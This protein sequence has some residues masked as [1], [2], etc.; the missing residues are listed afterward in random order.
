[1]CFFAALVEDVGECKCDYLKAGRRPKKA[2]KVTSDTVMVKMAMA[3]AKAI[4]NS[5]YGMV[6]ICVLF[7]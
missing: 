5:L 1:V 2:T 7:V 6:T 3:R 4:V